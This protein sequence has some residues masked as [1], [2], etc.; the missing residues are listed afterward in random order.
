M[1]NVLREPTFV[2][3]QRRPYVQVDQPPNLAANFFPKVA[4][5]TA[6][7][8]MPDRFWPRP[9]VQDFAVS[10]ATTRGIPAQPSQPRIIR[11]P[12]YAPIFPRPY[13][14][15][16][17]LQSLVLKTLTAASPPFRP[18]QFPEIFRRNIGDFYGFEVQGYLQGPVGAPF[19][20]VEFPTPMRARSTPQDFTFASSAIPPP[21]PFSQDDWPIPIRVRA[22]HQDFWWTGITTRGIPA[23]VNAPFKQSDWP[24]PRRKADQY[25]DVY[26][27]PHLL[28][29]TPILRPFSQSEWINPRRAALTP[30]DWPWSGFTTRGIPPIPPPSGPFDTVRLE[31]YSVNLSTG[32]SSIELHWSSA[33][34]AA[35]YRLYINGVPQPT[36]LHDRILIVTGLAIDTQY[37]FEIV[38]VNAFDHDASDLSNPVYW[39]LDSRSFMQVH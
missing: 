24:D 26:S 20:P 3:I 21:A 25:S 18:P 32:T 1:A 39:S 23:G 28:L 15:Q 14:Q 11:S 12:T 30:I 38:C 7:E 34:G 10:G 36:V 8:D 19:I 5:F 22:L 17:Q 2:P 6:R 27:S 4:P 29:V 35:G 33:L 31:I 16:E 13:L 9:P 37:K